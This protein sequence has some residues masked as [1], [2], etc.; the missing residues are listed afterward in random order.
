MAFPLNLT[1]KRISR[2]YPS[3]N[4]L[5]LFDVLIS[6]GVKIHAEEYVQKSIRSQMDAIIMVNHP[7][8]KKSP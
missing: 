7:E 4:V 6:K 5:P 8:L 2:N 3:V 1:G